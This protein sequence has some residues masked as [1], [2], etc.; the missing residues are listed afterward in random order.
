MI[1][2]I[3]APVVLAIL[4][5]VVVGTPAFAQAND[6]VRGDTEGSSE[7]LDRAHRG[8]RAARGEIR[9]VDL[10]GSTFDLWL[11]NDETVTIAVNDQTR[12]NGQ[13]RSLAD[14]E[15]GMQAG[16]VARFQPDGP[17]LAL[18]VVVPPVRPKLT[19][20]AGEISAVDL[21]DSLLTLETRHAGA[22]TFAVLDST[23]FFGEAN[24][25]R[26]LEI[27]APALVVAYTDEDGR[28]VAG[29]VG[30]RAKQQ[31]KR[32]AGEIT[33]VQVEA[34]NFEMQTLK[35]EAVTL[36]VDAETQFRGADQDI[37]GLGDLQPGMRAVVGAILL[38]DGTLLARAVVVGRAIGDRLDIRA[39]GEITV[40][41]SDTIS[42][43][44]RD[45][46]DLQVTID[47]HTRFISQEGDVEGLE[48]LSVG[49]QIIVGATQLESAELLARVVAVPG[50][51]R[52]E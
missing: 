4:V 28:L 22:I 13:V 25:L 31:V 11:P 18:L 2:R 44:T 20:Y 17:P 49:M 43:I 15:P 8:R 27:G 10:A 50:S 7:G 21:E 1:K 19:R 12:F 30:V 3:L 42:L 14:L 40:I 38:D 41:G 36:G 32:F 23:R 16:V 45:S 24:S 6:P 5:S 35:G 26:D 9:A 52:A 33:S 34:G 46:R 51:D 37:A 39:R 48:D 29:A 47:S